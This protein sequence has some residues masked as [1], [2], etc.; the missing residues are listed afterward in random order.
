MVTD[1]IKDELLRPLPEV[2]P[3]GQEFVSRPNI[4]LDATLSKVCKTLDETTVGWNLT[5]GFT[6]ACEACLNSGLPANSVWPQLEQFQKVQGRGQYFTSGIVDETL[7]K[8]MG[9]S[10]RNLSKGQIWLVQTLYKEHVEATRPGEKTTLYEIAVAI[11]YQLGYRLSVRKIQALLLTQKT[12]TFEHRFERF[13]FPSNPVNINLVDKTTGYGVYC[14]LGVL[15]E[16]VTPLPPFAL[17]PGLGNIEARIDKLNGVYTFSNLF[18]KT[19]C[20][21][22][23]DGTAYIVEASV[24]NTAHFYRT[25]GLSNSGT[26]ECLIVPKDWRSLVDHLFNTA[27]RALQ[28]CE[29]IRLQNGNVLPKLMI[30]SIANHE[31]TL[32]DYDA[33]GTLTPRA[34]Y[35]DLVQKNLRENLKKTVVWPPPTNGG[36]FSFPP[37]GPGPGPGPGSA[38]GDPILSTPKFSGPYTP[39]TIVTPEDRMRSTEAL[40]DRL[41][42]IKKGMGITDRDLLP[43]DVLGNLERYSNRWKKA[44]PRDVVEPAFGTNFTTQL[45]RIAIGVLENTAARRGRSLPPLLEECL[46]AMAPV[47]ESP[48]VVAVVVPTA[49]VS[50]VGILAV[51]TRGSVLD[52]P[53]V[54]VE[55]PGVRLKSLNTGQGG[56]QSLLNEGAIVETQAA[57]TITER[58]TGTVE[59]GRSLTIT[60]SGRI[61][62]RASNANEAT[63]GQKPNVVVVNRLEAAGIQVKAIDTADSDGH[64]TTIGVGYGPPWAKIVPPLKFTFTTDQVVDGLRD[65]VVSVGTRRVV[66]HLTY[67]VHN[68]TSNVWTFLALDAIYVIASFNPTSVVILFF[69]EIFK[70]K[71]EKLRLPVTLIVLG[72]TFG[73]A[74]VTPWSGLC[75]VINTTLTAITEPMYRASL[76]PATPR[77]NLVSGDDST[78][79][80][81]WSWQLFRVI[82]FSDPLEVTIIT[83]HH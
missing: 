7:K 56:A 12:L 11:E 32:D 38:G 14:G 61:V 41:R 39:K 55:L 54:V 1:R 80:E 51:G 53:D 4:D 3:I 48:P 69:F 44:A 57:I 15:T 6:E 13:A 59:R 50:N 63:I 30:T 73:T 29:D 79:R 16:P 24:F 23:G 47:V 81:A 65:G 71:T 19:L 5:D 60:D 67:A 36:T 75:F 70:E 66:Q 8:L 27:T 22:R 31:H 9:G 26:T 21:L 62:S 20:D 43:N 35:R 82:C 68:G 77:K 37:R 58:V 40:R 45:A 10:I 34:K 64:T 25:I 78:T 28:R 83:V 74:P 49:N 17:K 46:T 52:L 76:P 2:Q 42:S 72:F 33:V 18:D